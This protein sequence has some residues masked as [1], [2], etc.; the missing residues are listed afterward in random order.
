[1][2]PFHPIADSAL[3]PAGRYR[4]LLDDAT[5]TVIKIDHRAAVTV[6]VRAPRPPDTSLRF[7]P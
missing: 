2:V 4:C 5:P 3:P 6:R 1:M 7:L